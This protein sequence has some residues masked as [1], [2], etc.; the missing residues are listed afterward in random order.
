MYDVD[1]DFDQ[2]RDNASSV[3]CVFVQKVE[4]RFIERLKVV[5][6]EQHEDNAVVDVQIGD[7]CQPVKIELSVCRERIKKKKRK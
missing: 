2:I 1:H 4:W 5:V 7:E 6:H 3:K